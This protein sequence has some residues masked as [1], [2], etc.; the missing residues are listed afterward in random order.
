M[1]AGSLA[2]ASLGYFLFQQPLIMVLV[3]MMLWAPLLILAT[4]LRNTGSLV[5]TIE[6]AIG[7]A[8]LLLIG[9]HLLVDDL[10]MFWTEFLNSLFDQ[11]LD[12]SVITQAER[13]DV[14]TRFAPWMSGILAAGWLMQLSMSIFLARYWQAALY[15]PEGFASE[16]HQFRLRPWFLILMVALM[17]LGMLFEPEG[18]VSQLSLIGVTALFIQGLAL[19]HGLVKQLKLKGH[20]LVGFYLFLIF[21]LPLSWTV[22]SAIGFIDGWLDF[23]AKARMQ[24]GNGPQA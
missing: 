22:V 18:L 23:R 17:A 4:V 19:V 14:V 13:D 16:F 15:K 7:I 3:A 8:T 10:I 1:L 24:A 2:V 12:T 20:W 5:Y 11:V 6:A 21:G 9:E